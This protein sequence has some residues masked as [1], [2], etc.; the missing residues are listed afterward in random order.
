MHARREKVNA[1]DALYSKGE[2]WSPSTPLN[3]FCNPIPKF[4]LRLIRTLLDV[5]TLLCRLSLRLFKSRTPS[6]L[7]LI[8]ATFQVVSCSLSL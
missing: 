2:C 5:L 1:F 7:C 6:F 8:H 4:F 3:G